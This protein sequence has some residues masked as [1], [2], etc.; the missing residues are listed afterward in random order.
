VRCSEARALGKEGEL[1]RVI[2]LTGIHMTMTGLTESCYSHTDLEPLQAV[3]AWIKKMDMLVL[4]NA[5]RV[6]V[7]GQPAETTEI[8]LDHHLL[9]LVHIAIRTRIARALAGN[10][11]RRDVRVMA[12]FHSI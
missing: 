5:C 10:I 4:N 9:P 8:Q 6:E 2:A 3:L 12:P 7:I 1:L 11:T